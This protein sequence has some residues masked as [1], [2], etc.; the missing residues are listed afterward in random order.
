MVT[1]ERARQIRQEFLDKE[2]ILEDPKLE[3]TLQA[4]E[5][6]ASQGKQYIVRFNV[7]DRLM[8]NLKNLGYNIG[9]DEDTGEW[10]ISW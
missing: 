1:A 3:H 8:K 5:E 2:A 10:T 9:Y 4:V 6:A 7:T